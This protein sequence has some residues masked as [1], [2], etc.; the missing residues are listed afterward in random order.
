MK[1]CVARSHGVTG[2]DIAPMAAHWMKKCASGAQDSLISEKW[3]RFAISISVLLSTSNRLAF[4]C[5]LCN[6]SH[7]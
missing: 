1:L 7:R 4:T 6:N 3:I 5:R 2:R